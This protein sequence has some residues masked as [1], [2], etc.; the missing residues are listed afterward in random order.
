[1]KGDTYMERIDRK[2]ILECCL[3]IFF[4]FSILSGIFEDYLFFKFRYIAAIFV[5]FI[6]IKDRRITCNINRNNVFFILIYFFS[7]MF[8][9]SFYNH[10]TDYVF[11]LIE[12]IYFLLAYTLVLENISNHIFDILLYTLHI[13]CGVYYVLKLG[14]NQTSLL[15]CNVSTNYISVYYIILFVLYLMIGGEKNRDLKISHLIFASIFSLLAG[16]R[17]GI[18]SI[19]VIIIILLFIKK[20]KKSSIIITTFLGLVMIMVLLINCSKISKI[21]YRFTEMGM[22]SNG[23]YK[24]WM[25]YLNNC[26]TSFTNMIWG[27]NIQKS[28]SRYYYYI[29]HLHNSYLTIYGYCGL[30]PTLYLIYMFIRSLKI[31]WKKGYKVLTAVLLS[32]FLRSYT[33]VVFGGF[34]GD[35]VVYSIICWVNMN[36]ES[37]ME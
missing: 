30:I 32:F 22:N 24:F 7:G 21:F 5:I 37:K 15:F 17:G 16:G 27:T 29:P 23:R 8:F 33:D 20:N 36:T 35:V 14:G 31:T 26:K 10:N 6:E 18:L 9:V 19:G 12:I 4:G 1:M 25:D 11:W 28:L 13:I 2:F 3:I 34:I